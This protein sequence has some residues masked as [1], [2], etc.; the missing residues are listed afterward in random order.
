MFIIIICL[1][2]ARSVK[3]SINGWHAKSYINGFYNDL[4]VAVL[5]GGAGC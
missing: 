4:G 3:E 1:G 5:K 2:K